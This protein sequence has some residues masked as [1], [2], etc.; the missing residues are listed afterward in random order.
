MVPLP[1]GVI[2]IAAAVDGTSLRAAAAAAIGE[3]GGVAN[4]IA[5]SPTDAAAEASRE[6]TDGTPIY[7]NGLATLYGM[8]VVQVPGL[9]QSLVYDATRV[10]FI[11]RDDLQLEASAEAGFANDTTLVCIKGRFAVAVPCVDKSIRK[12]T[13]AGSPAA[14]RA[15]AKKG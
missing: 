12:L 11:V 3:E 9:T 10:L 7:P 8:K 5:L 6:A 15:I 4:T 2:G 13:V 14:Q 1:V